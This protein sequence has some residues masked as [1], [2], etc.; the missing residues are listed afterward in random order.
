MLHST[1]QLPLEYEEEERKKKNMFVSFELLKE[2]CTRSQSKHLSA[3][4]C[5]Y[6]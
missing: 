2:A 4:A 5:F 3:G 1:L 6:R